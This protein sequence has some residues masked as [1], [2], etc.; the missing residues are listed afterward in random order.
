MP[1]IKPFSPLRP[2]AEYVEDMYIYHGDAGNKK[3]VYA[4][5]ASNPKSLIH[6]SHADISLSEEDAKNEKLVRAKSKEAMKLFRKEGLLKQEKE[7]S[8][9]IYR[10]SM[11]NHSQ[12]GVVALVDVEDYI[13]GIVK[14]HEL[15]RVDK[16]HTQ[17][18]QIE[19]VG[20][21]MEP[22]LLAYD[23]SEPGMATEGFLKEWTLSHDSEYDFFDMGGIHHELWPITD[24]DVNDRIT[25]K[26]SK[27]SSFYICDGHHRIA[28]AAEYYVEHVDPNAPKEPEPKCRYFMAAIFPSD[29]MLVLDYNRAV[30]DLNGLTKEQFFQALRDGN[31][32]LRELGPTPT[33]PSGFGEFTMVM[34][35]TWYKLTYKGERDMTDPVASLD[36]SLLQSH[37]LRDI[38]GIRDP[39][40]DERLAFISGTKGLE[41][42]QQAT[43]KDM[44]VA[45]AIA[46]PSMSD[47]IK[48]SDTGLTMPPKSTCF[49]PKLASGLLIYQV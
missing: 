7:E 37:V 43:E 45:F 21:H 39:Q 14:R 22:I 42:L 35:G 38:L 30:K 46:P 18:N 27:A 23:T 15:T 33:Y 8:Y 12:T 29:E 11:A 28:A 2:A 24:K 34:D 16:V 25:E 31:F 5:F 6:I 10:L 17:A 26:L 13:N 3:R 48:V 9:Y 20:G 40:N 19:R 1:K 44:A 4:L 36:V 32:R 49:E 47:I 41:A